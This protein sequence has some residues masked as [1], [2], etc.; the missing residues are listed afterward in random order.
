MNTI[1]LTDCIPYCDSVTIAPATTVRLIDAPCV[2]IQIHNWTTN[3]G[4]VTAAGA[5]ATTGVAGATQGTAAMG[6]ATTNPSSSPT[7]TEI[8]YG[9]N[10]KLANQVFAGYSSEILPV[11]NLNRITLRPGLAGGRSVYYTYWVKKP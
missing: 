7:G 3:D 5:V 1:D 2:A 4:T 10:G 8:Y 11:D 9:F 6:A